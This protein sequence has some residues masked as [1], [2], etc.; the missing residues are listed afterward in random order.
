MLD[1][2]QA[3]VTSAALAAC[4]ARGVALTV[5]DAR[6]MPAGIALPFHQHHLQAGLAREQAKAGGPLKKRL[7]TRIVKTK[8]LNQAA[9]LESAGQEGRALR[10]MAA[11][12]RSGDP[13][14]VEARAAREYWKL[15]FEDFRRGD[16]GDGRNGFLNYGYAILRSVIARALTAHGMVP[17]LGLHHDGAANPFNLAD[18]LIEPFRPLAD[19]TVRAVLA[20]RGR[21]A[22][23]NVSD[24]RSLAALPQD[25][26][27][28]GGEIM[29]VLSAAEVSAASLAIAFREKDDARLILPG[30]V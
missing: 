26:A 14:N 29:A 15:F 4:F 10:A 6:H 12:V 2:P 3:T 28:I 5:S 9:A 25:E 8:I 20:G 21:E 17:A 7:W 24:R 13:D 19:L 30:L 27:R 1:T 11:R 18:D 16:G 23:M 22:E